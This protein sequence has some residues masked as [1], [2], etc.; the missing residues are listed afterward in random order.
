MTRFA[1]SQLSY[2]LPKLCLS[3]LLTLQ[4]VLTVVASKGLMCINE[5]LAV[6]SGSSTRV[7]LISLLHK[8]TKSVKVWQLSVD[9]AK[10]LSLLRAVRYIHTLL[11]VWP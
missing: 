5:M 1:R 2:N 10:Q 3:K 6:R 4:E 9:M 8:S 11:H 7:S